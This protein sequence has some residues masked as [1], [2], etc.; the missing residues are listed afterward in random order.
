[1]LRPLQ[2][3]LVSRLLTSETRTQI[4]PQTQ[5]CVHLGPGA[6]A[7]HLPHTTESSNS[8]PLLQLTFHQRCQRTEMY[9][10][11]EDVNRK[12]SPRDVEDGYIPKEG[13]K[14]VCIHSS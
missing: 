14:F 5:L 8:V 13:S 7:P 2:V 10:A 11:E 3:E 12:S 6:A 4:L 1:M 9:L